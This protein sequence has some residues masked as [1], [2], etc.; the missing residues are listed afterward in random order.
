MEQ[1][2]VGDFLIAS[3]AAIRQAGELLVGYSFSIVGA[4]I[5][6]VVGWLAARFLHRWALYGMRQIRGFDV[7]LA[8]FLANVIRYAVLVLV[9]VTVLG[10]SGLR[11]A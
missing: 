10:L 4:L 2:S 7:T 11:N 8:H 9:I 5:L 1:Q 6:L 3:R